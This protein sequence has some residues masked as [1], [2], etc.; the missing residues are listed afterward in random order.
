MFDLNEKSL[1]VETLINKCIDRYIK[2]RQELTESANSNVVID[3]KMETVIE[4]MFKRCFA[5]K[6]WKQAIGIALE[7]RRLDK[8]RDAI[9]S[10]N[11]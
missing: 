2:L 10:S 9:E 1:Y 5:D 4:K 8:V 7:S 11:E 6:R 3:A